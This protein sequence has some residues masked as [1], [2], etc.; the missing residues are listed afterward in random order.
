MHFSIISIIFFV[1]AAV[2]S[3]VGALTDTSSSADG[4][5]AEAS[6]T[7]TEVYSGTQAANPRRW[8]LMVLSTALF[9][10]VCAAI[11]I[12]GCFPSYNAR[13]VSFYMLASVF[14]FAFG[15]VYA[16]FQDCTWSLLPP[17]ADI[18]NLMGF[19]AMAKLAGIGIGNFIVGLILDM[20]QNGS[21]SH[22]YAFRGYV[23]MCF[24]CATV[25]GLSA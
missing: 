15:S 7:S 5:P 17:S 4:E 19:A 11:P 13:M 20:Y 2:A 25:V 6:S 1:C 9:A 14:G 21:G 23:L 12:T 10:V 3:S 16:R 22:S 8:P 24:F 18:A